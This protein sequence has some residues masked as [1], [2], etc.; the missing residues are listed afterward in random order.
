M[1]AQQTRNARFGDIVRKKGQLEPLVLW[2]D[3]EK[4]PQLK[5]A[6]RENRVM[7]LV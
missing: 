1:K 2:G 3:P 4:Y 7:T 5:R 6:I